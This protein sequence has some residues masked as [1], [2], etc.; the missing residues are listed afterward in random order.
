MHNNGNDGAA[1]VGALDIGAV[2]VVGRRF[3]IIDSLGLVLSLR[4]RVINLVNDVCTNIVGEKT[5]LLTTMG[6]YNGANRDGIVC[7]GWVQGVEL[8]NGG[9]VY[10]FG[11]E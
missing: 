9:L 2:A 7:A 10:V 11:E 8:L 4:L 6:I 3:I 5:L 1:L